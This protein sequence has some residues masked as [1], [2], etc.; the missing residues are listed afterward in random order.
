MDAP[1]AARSGHQGTA[2]A[3]APLAHVLWTRVMRY[4]ASRPGL[5]R[6]RPLRPVGRTR[7]DPALLDAPPHRLRPDARRPARS[8][9]SGA[10]ARRATPRCTTPRAS[11]SPPGRSA[12]VRQ[13]RRHGASP[14]A[15]LRS[16]FGADDLRPPHFVHRQRRRPGGGRQPRGR[17]ASPGTWGWAGSSYVYDDNHISIDGPTELAFSDDAATRFRAYGWHVE[18]ARR[19]R[20]R[21]R[22]PRGGAA[23]RGGGRGPPVAARAAQPHRLPVARSTPTTTRPTATPSATRRSAPPR[24]PRPAPRRDLLRPRRRPRPATAPPVTGGHGA[25]R[26]V[27]EAA[28]RVGRRP[29]RAGGVPGRRRA[30]RAGTPGSA[31]LGAR[32]QGRHPQGQRRLRPGA[33]STTSRPRWPAV[34][35]SPATPA[36]S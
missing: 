27:G 30:C 13:R 21:P 8:S 28:R 16:R 24:S 6:P 17:L 10:A 5:A 31:E 9:G 7:V 22:R 11:R 34:P 2:M 18:R 4:D 25:R 36:P 19:D 12:R 35:T 33:R 14:S 20:Q 29:R 23:P 3:L 26:G 1:H 15:S 32:R